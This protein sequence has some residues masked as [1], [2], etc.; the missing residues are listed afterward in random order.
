ML[1]GELPDRGAGV[2]ELA[3]AKIQLGLFV[4][5]QAFQRRPRV[6]HQDEAI[7]R[8]A[9]E[10]GCDEGLESL[11]GQAEAPSELGGVRRHPG[12]ARAQKAPIELL[13]IRGDRK[14]GQVRAHREPTSS[15]VVP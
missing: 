14:D 4:P 8:L 3:A 9:D 7:G 10:S 15:R 6:F 2:R 13:G 1:G 12:G 11:G 5:D